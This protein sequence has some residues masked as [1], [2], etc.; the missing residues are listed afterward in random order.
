MERYIYIAGA[1]S[2][3]Q[4]TREYFEFLYPGLKVSAYLV[5]PEMPDCN[6]II[7]GI[8]VL[9]IADNQKLNTAWDVFIATR[10][11]NHSKIKSELLRIGFRHIIPVTPELDTKLRNLYVNAIFEKENRKFE[12]INTINQAEIPFSHTSETEKSIKNKLSEVNTKQSGLKQSNE[13]S[14]SK[15]GL[16]SNDDNVACIYVV[17]TAG[18]HALKETYHLLSEERIIQAGASLTSERIPGAY[19]T[20][21]IGENI[22]KRNRQFC[23]LTALYWIWKHAHQ[24]YIGIVHYRRHFLLPNDWLTRMKTFH[25]DVLLLDQIINNG[26]IKLLLF[27]LRKSRPID[28]SNDKQQAH[29]FTSSKY[30]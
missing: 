20:D 15:K 29:D 11:V 6:S 17:S 7:N 23:E 1:S 2:R 5:S 3:A 19:A 18:E 30:K 28:I 13:D 22:S 12:K 14:F 4:T 16:S 8:D 26:Y 10:G 24:N 21:D 9:P 25:I 27:L